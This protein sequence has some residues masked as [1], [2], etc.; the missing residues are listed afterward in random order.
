MT[1]WQAAW[2]FGGDA[3]LATEMS[4]GRTRSR[5]ARTSSSSAAARGSWRARRRAPPSP[6]HRRSRAHPRR[7][8]PAWATRH[9]PATPRP[10]SRSCRAQTTTRRPRRRSR[11]TRP[12]AGSARSVPAGESPPVQAAASARSVPAEEPPPAIMRSATPEP[13]GGPGRAR[14]LRRAPGARTDGAAAQGAGAAGGADR[15][16]GCSARS[17]LSRGPAVRRARA[18]QGARDPGPGARLPAP[19]DECADRAARGP[20]RRRGGL[21]AHGAAGAGSGRDTRRRRSH[22]SAP[23]RDQVPVPSRPRR[24]RG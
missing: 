12:A 2:L 21:R 23:V 7:I 9:R 10:P 24:R 5:R 11:V 20:G 17:A 3:D 4:S 1:D 8:R 22:P 16:R 19:R 15:G 6:R 13:A 14:D 18:R